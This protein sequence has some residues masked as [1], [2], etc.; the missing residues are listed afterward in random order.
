MKMQSILLCPEVTFC[1]F[2]LVT[3]SLCQC[4][5]QLYCWTLAIQLHQNLIEQYF[6]S[7]FVHTMVILQYYEK[8]MRLEKNAIHGHLVNKWTVYLS[9]LWQQIN[10]ITYFQLQKQ[11][12]IGT[13]MLLV[14]LLGYIFIVGLWKSVSH[15]AIAVAI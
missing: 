10:S 4:S 15:S 9:L 6:D 3:F 11:Y 14:I 5:S 13:K 12:F 7:I 2:N 1:P 8:K